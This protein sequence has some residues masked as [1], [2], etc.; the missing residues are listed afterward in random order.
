MKNTIFS[1]IRTLVFCAAIFILALAAD[2]I[3]QYTKSGNVRTTIVKVTNFAGTAVI[4]QAGGSLSR[5]NHGVFATISTSSLTPGNVVTLWWA[6]FNN[7]EFCATPSCTAPDL[8][9]PL[10]NG[11]VQ[12]GGGS[13]VGSGGRADFSGYL[14]EGD[15]TGFEILPPFPNMPNPAPGIVDAKTATIHL[16]MRNHGP[17]S[18]DPVVLAQQLTTFLGGC[19]AMNPCA[20]IQAAQFLQ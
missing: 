10:V 13:I 18:A 14:D 15:N 4:P 20:N 16:V 11:S 1:R 17:A 7:P 8:N 5:N 6:V 2:S 12:Y 3:A 19:S 9:N